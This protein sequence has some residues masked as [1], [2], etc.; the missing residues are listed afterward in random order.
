MQTLQG[1]EIVKSVFNRSPDGQKMF[2]VLGKQYIGDIAASIVD[3][4]GSINWEKAAKIATD[5]HTAKIIEEI[6][7]KETLNFFKNL[8]RYSK[9]ISSNIARFNSSNPGVFEKTLNIAD[10][11][12]K[13]EIPT[14]A[15]IG[16]LTGT[17]I[18]PGAAGTYA[19]WEIGKK[20][21]YKALS[22]PKVQGA[23]QSLSNPSN[24][25]RKDLENILYEASM[26]INK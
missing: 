18:S 10:G 23:I 6:A 8:G 14:K 24:Y 7:G 16:F 9:N 4:N 22:N 25:N 19:S 15:L 11:T 17:F 3:K 12:Y 5:P 2:K 1:Y 13:G 20:L 26:S 21:F